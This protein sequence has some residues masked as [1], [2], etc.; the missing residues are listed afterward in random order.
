VVDQYAEDFEIIA[1]NYID[2]LD[3]LERKEDLEKIQKL[4][5]EKLA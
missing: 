2:Y 4:K 3:L 1:D 5:N